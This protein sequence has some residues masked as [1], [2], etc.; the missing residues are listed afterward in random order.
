MRSTSRSAANRRRNRAPR[1]RVAGWYRHHRLCARQSLLSLL[2]QPISSA[3]T[4]LV[5][6]IALLLP[7]LLYIALQALEQQSTKWQEG[8]Q[9]TLYLESGI[10]D[11]DALTL[12]S[13]LAQR[14]EVLGT[15]YLSKEEAWA[16][17]Q[18]QIS[19]PSDRALIDNPLPPSIVLVPSQQSQIDLE[20]LLLILTD[21]PEVT[22]V[23]VDLAWIRQLKRL[24]SLAQLIVQILGLVL[25]CALLL[26]VG[27]T[28][29][30][31]IESQ[32][33]DIQIIKLLGASDDYVRRPFLYLGLWYGVI[34][35]LAALAMLAVI[36]S[37]VAP[38][39][40]VFLSAYG[41][42]APSLLLSWQEFGWLLFIAVGV[43]S[44]GARIALWRH[45]RKI[46]PK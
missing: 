8:G 18:T 23:Q 17:F 45:L 11:E 41:V 33:S 4:W 1:L 2:R 39:L 28:I 35:A 13:E 25:A 46:D 38:Q 37:A 31:S 3:L 6:A 20:A 36:N 44:T 7:S 27:N 21:L 32:K 10:S 42:T 29:R 14:K 15:Q 30:L 24:L 19:L 12:S 26:V 5:I 40:G 9:I 43:S 22:E 16:D 34:G